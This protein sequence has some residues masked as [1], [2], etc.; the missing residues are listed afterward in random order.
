M[1]SAGSVQQA[2][3][4]SWKLTVSGGFDGSGKRIR[5]TKTVKCTSEQQAK[6]ELALFVAEI[7]KGQISTSGKMT[8][9][10]FF[11]YWKTN[12]AIKNLSPMT[13]STYEHIFKRISHALGRKRIDKIEPIHLNAFFTNLQ[14]PILTDKEGNPAH[15]APA[16]IKKHHELLSIMFNKAVK[17]NLIPYNPITRIET[18]KLKR[19]PKKIY[20]QDTLGKFLL[21]LA[22]EPIKYQ[23]MVLL[24]LTAS[25]R[26]EEIF[27]LEW[28]H[29]DLDNH[30]IH[31]EQ[32]AIYVPQQGIILKETKTHSSNRVVSISESMV[33]MLK[34]H[35]AEEAAKQLELGDKWLKGEDHS[36]VFTTW[37]GTTAHPHSVNTWL[38]K[39][40]ASND[41]PNIG[42]HA[43]RHMNATYLIMGG[44]DIRTV[45]GKLGH[46][47]PSVTMDIYSHL[48]KSAEKETTNIMDK[49]IRETTENARLKEKKQAK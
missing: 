30:T 41:L 7:E 35:K 23:I 44:V 6:K 19:T 3:K 21:L 27:G 5:H 32:A 17:W 11:D 49:F 33:T 46:A 48:V 18:P 40:I 25:F 20:D 45:A 13:L 37:N 12:H 34:K 47:K 24:A 8:L 36:F 4:S 9:I 43:F 28:R 2:G 1:A 10:D 29:I 14:E 38:K 22:N 31:I 39:F 42:I 16:T 26:R 15:M